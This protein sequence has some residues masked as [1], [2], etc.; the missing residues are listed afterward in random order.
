MRRIVT[1]AT[2]RPL[3]DR[4][5]AGVSVT[6]TPESRLALVAT[7]TREAWSL[8]GL[9]EPSYERSTMPVRVR[10]LRDASA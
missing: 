3:R 10:P 8:A 7:L 5:D 2:V 4:P 1:S 6:G 9:P